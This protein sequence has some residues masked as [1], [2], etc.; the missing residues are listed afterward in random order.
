MRGKG[1]WPGGAS[2][3]LLARGRV[4]QLQ[5]MVLRCR[6]EEQGGGSAW[7]EEADDPGGP[8]LG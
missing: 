1:R 5:N 3:C 4:G 2:I 6:P 7:Q 8:V